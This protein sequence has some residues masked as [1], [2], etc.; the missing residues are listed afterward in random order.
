M[1]GFGSKKLSVEDI[2]KGK[3]LDRA[4]EKT[5]QNFF[6]NRMTNRIRKAMVGAWYILHE[7]DDFVYWGKPRFSGIFSNGRIV[8]Q[9][10]KTSKAELSQAFPNYAKTAGNDVRLK[11]VDYIGNYIR[12][13]FGKNYVENE[14]GSRTH[15]YVTVS[16]GFAYGM[17][18]FLGSF[19]PTMLLPARASLFL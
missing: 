8:E 10:F 19:S 11:L 17:T 4:E 1:F 7:D 16:S 18:N 9:L 5:V 6:Q 14:D 3:H 15:Y 2:K 13:N 12:P